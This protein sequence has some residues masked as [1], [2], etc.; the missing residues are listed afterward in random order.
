MC[1][2]EL[3]PEVPFLNYHMLPLEAK[4]QMFPLPVCSLNEVVNKQLIE[5]SRR[6]VTFKGPYLCFCVFQPICYS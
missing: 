4:W 3:V 5:L 1:K 2:D 6:E